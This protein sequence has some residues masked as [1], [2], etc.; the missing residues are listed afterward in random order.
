[1]ER[2]DLDERRGTWEKKG[3]ERKVEAR[4]LRKRKER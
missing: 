4:H 1:M 3:E 2:R